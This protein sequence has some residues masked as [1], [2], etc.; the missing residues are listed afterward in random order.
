M[1]FSVSS[2]T[3]AKKTFDFRSVKRLL[4][5]HS[6]TVF[7]TQVTNPIPRP[8]PFKKA[9][10]GRNQCCKMERLLSLKNGLD[11][12]DVKR[13][14]KLKSTDWPSLLECCRNMV[15]MADKIVWEALVR[16]EEAPLLQ[17]HWEALI[18]AM[19][20]SALRSSVRKLEYS[21]ETLVRQP[22]ALFQHLVTLFTVLTKDLVSLSR[23]I[24]KITSSEAISAVQSAVDILIIYIKK[25]TLPKIPSQYCTPSLI[26]RSRSWL[27]ATAL[28]RH[29][30]LDSSTHK[31]SQKGLNQ[32]LDRCATISA[33]SASS[34]SAHGS[35]AL[36]AISGISNV[37]SARRFVAEHHVDASTHIVI[38]ANW[39]IVELKK[40]YES[41]RLDYKRSKHWP[42]FHYQRRFT[43]DPES[44]FPSII[45]TQPSSLTPLEQ[46]FVE[47][48]ATT[49]SK[50]KRFFNF[51]SKAPRAI[52]S[53][54]LPTISGE[55][56]LDPKTFI[57]K[58]SQIYY[59]AYRER[60]SRQF[61]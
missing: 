4:A 19:S 45:I 49:L 32:P 2:A 31:T 41:V 25:G 44:R 10:I 47:E 27:I 17:P 36:D 56:A 12:G 7:A 22:E 3:P 38:D 8:F 15:G 33:A 28:P 6:F 21:L 42:T 40:V 48:I 13:L 46:T 35:A 58:L 34:S 16:C 59:T 20:T 61:F 51:S 29:S 24:H 52:T 26:A 37:V 5:P 60:W 53:C 23:H 54:G 57:K 1:H 18:K 30:L 9:H 14:N 43:T 55:D 39:T 50:T 11:T